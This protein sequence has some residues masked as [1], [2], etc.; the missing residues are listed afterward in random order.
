MNVRI[1]EN[2]NSNMY[3][4]TKFSSTLMKSNVQK[5]W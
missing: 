4:D 5:N 2:C 3:H 1:R